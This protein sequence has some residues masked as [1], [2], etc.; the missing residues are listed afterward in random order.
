MGTEAPLVYDSGLAVKEFIYNE[1]GEA[2]WHE[3]ARDPA[4]IVGWLCTQKGD[5]IWKLIEADPN[6]A[7]RYAIALQT[8]HYRLYRLN[9]GTPIRDSGRFFDLESRISNR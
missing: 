1:G 8:E 3:A 7:G 6:W 4:P 2:L 5:S 9:K